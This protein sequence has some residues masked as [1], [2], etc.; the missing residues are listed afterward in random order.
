MRRRVVITGMGILTAL[1]R[2][3]SDTLSALESGVTGISKIASFV[4][5]NYKVDA[6]AEVKDIFIDKDFKE[7]KEEKLDRSSYLILTACRDAL[8]NASLPRDGVEF[9]KIPIFLGTTL[10]GMLSGQ[11]FHSDYFLERN[12]ENRVSLLKDYLAC[13]QAVHIA[14]E[15]GF[16][17]E[18]MVLNNACSSGSSAIGLAFRRLSS[19]SAPFAVAGG[20]DVMSAFTHAG[21]SSL[22]LI[23]S[24]KCRPFDKNRSG[25]LL[26]EGAGVIVLEELDHALNRRA[27]I[28]SEV[29]GFGQSSDAYHLTKPDPEAQGACRA[30][31]MAIN[32]AEISAHDIDYINAHGTGTL[33][34]DSMETKAIKMAL[35]D[36]G[37]KVPVSSTKAMTGHTLGAAGAVEV[38][39]SAIAM[40]H[41][42][43]PV[44]LNYEMPDPDCMLNIVSGQSRAAEIKIALSNSFGFG[45]S[46]VAILLRK[47]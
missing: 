24:E 39:I 28:I 19:G 7:N 41:N 27:D 32:D 33:A 42:L 26:G 25:L 4:T 22:Q 44:N 14:R 38:I 45:G 16:S 18:V 17:G 5:E 10:G 8:S 12:K 9:K 34:N 11:R 46:N 6:G 13:N 37:V 36:H 1:G 30:I 3:I 47:Y 31:A 29:I 20:Y 43:L 15:F 40:K 21:F 23:S 2:G 35:G